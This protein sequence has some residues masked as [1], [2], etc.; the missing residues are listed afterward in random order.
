MEP[1]FLF[2]LLNK[3]EMMTLIKKYSYISFTLK[4]LV[5]M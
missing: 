1:K 4:G 3:N 5:S 2:H